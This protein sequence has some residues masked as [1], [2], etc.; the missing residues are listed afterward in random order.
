ME[1]QFEISYFDCYGNQMGTLDYGH[2]IKTLKFQS[3][4]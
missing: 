4:V 2:K 1:V 3:I